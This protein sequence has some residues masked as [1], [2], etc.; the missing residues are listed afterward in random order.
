MRLKVAWRALTIHNFWNNHY[1][2]YNGLIDLNKFI[3][4]SSKSQVI[5]LVRMLS[6]MFYSFS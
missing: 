2:E 6:L 1:G 4:S 3:L 5:A